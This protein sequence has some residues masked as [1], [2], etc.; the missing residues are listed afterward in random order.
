MPTMPPEL[1]AVMVA[2]QPLFSKPVYPRALVL[3]CGALMAVRFRTVTAALRVMGLAQHADFACY[4]RVLSQRRWCL[5]RAAQ[6]LTRL[7]I[8]RFAG[9]RPLVFGL[10]DTTRAPLGRE[11]QSAGHLPRPGAFEPRPFC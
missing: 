2:F 10:D 6:I 7:L 1:A 5:R 11:D 4:H 8:E 3:L 9:E